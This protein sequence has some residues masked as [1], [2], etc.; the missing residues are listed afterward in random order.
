MVDLLVRDDRRRLQAER[1]GVVER[2]AHQDGGR[3][4]PGRNGIA[5]LRAPEL[6]AD[7]QSE[8]AD[9]FVEIRKG[10]GQ[11]LVSDD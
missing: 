10:L 3:E 11:F 7:Q 1:L 9:L 5:D 8:A 6:H 4:E 2:S